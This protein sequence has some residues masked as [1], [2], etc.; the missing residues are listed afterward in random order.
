MWVRVPAM[1]AVKMIARTGSPRRDV[2]AH[3]AI[4]A[5]TV[6]PIERAGRER[7]W[8]GA[9]PPAAE[10]P[11][12]P[13]AAPRIRAYPP[14]AAC[15]APPPGT[16][17]GTGAALPPLSAMTP[18]PPS[19]SRTSVWRRRGA[20]VRPLSAPAVQRRGAPDWNELD[21]CPSMSTRT[22]KSMNDK[23][24]TLVAY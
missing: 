16:A 15:P 5:R 21:N 7:P 2:M 10:A 1:T 18:K 3:W 22:H 9:V 13:A 24:L 17:P 8:A 11:E 12:P 6:A 20:L 19:R 4:E 14:A 23:Q